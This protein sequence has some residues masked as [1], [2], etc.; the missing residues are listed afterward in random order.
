MVKKKEQKPNVRTSE[1][2]KEIHAQGMFGAVSLHDTELLLY[3]IQRVKPQDKPVIFDKPLSINLAK[4]FNE[5]ELVVK[6]SI[7]IPSSQITL[8][9]EIFIDLEKRYE[10]LLSEKKKGKLKKKK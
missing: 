3:A 4:T 8:F 5:V 10:V 7:F 6:A 1:D 2:F 9:K